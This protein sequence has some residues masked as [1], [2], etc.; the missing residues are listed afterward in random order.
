MFLRLKFY[1]TFKTSRSNDIVNNTIKMKDLSFVNSPPLRGS[2]N[3]QITK[4]TPSNDVQSSG[5]D[6]SGFDNVNSVKGAF[7]TAGGVVANRFGVPS[8]VGRMLGRATYSAGE[9]IL[10]RRKQAETAM[11]A[12]RRSNSGETVTSDQTSDR[13]RNNN[14][15]NT[16]RGDENMNNKR[17]NNGPG[18]SDDRPG[19]RG[20]SATSRSNAPNVQLPVLTGHLTTIEGGPMPTHDQTTD[21]VSQL[22]TTVFSFGTW[23]ENTVG[24]LP[25]LYSGTSIKA[26]QIPLLF[27]RLLND[28]FAQTTTKFTDT[29]TQDNFQEYMQAFTQAIE[30]IAHVESVLAYNSRFGYSDKVIANEYL[31]EYYTSYSVNDDLNRLKSVLKNKYYPPKLVGM[32]HSAFQLYKLN[33]L[34]QSA[35]FR[36]TPRAR[37]I[38]QQTHGTGGEIRSNIRNEIESLINVLSNRQ[39]TLVSKA[40]G[41]VRPSHIFTTMPEPTPHAVYDPNMVELFVNLPRVYLAKSTDTNYTVFPNKG[42]LE[43]IP[44]VLNMEVDRANAT[45][46]ALQP[47]PKPVATTDTNYLDT[48]NFGATYPVSTKVDGSELSK[49]TYTKNFDNS[50]T[51]VVG[52]GDKRCWY[53]EDIA[54]SYCSGKLFSIQNAEFNPITPEGRTQDPTKFS[55]TPPTSQRVYFNNS[56]APTDAVRKLVDDIFDYS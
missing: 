39:N 8:S 53:S 45:I 23:S 6:L 36:L 47:Q 44:Y 46:F 5:A 9:R 10:G 48:V 33:D 38:P 55:I 31:Q 26:K 43:D 49:N 56:F 24:Y 22:S 32:I 37:L 15:K 4:F 34:E 17:R 25:N 16:G 2:N 21:Y 50:F 1:F 30:L 13:G 29:F 19:G 27:S 7:E 54:D 35:N 11:N 20:S 42:A 40:L 3:I 41:F 52:T 12:R 51:F 28:L 18:P 14:N